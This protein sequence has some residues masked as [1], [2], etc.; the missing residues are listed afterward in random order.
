[1]RKANGLL[2]KLSSNYHFI[3]QPCFL[4]ISSLKSENS[5]WGRQELAAL[6]LMK[7]A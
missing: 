5:A 3:V 7:T 4:Q 1:M 6:L 2:F